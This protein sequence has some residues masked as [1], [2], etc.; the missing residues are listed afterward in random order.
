MCVL[1]PTDLIY[2][3][4]CKFVRI[5]VRR[6]VRLKGDSNVLA[7][8]WSNAALYRHHTEHT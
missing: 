6:V 7:L 1:S 8:S 2:E 5:I 4:Y 3:L